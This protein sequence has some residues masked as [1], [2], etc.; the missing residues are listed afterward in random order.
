M[1]KTTT[2]LSPIVKQGQIALKDPKA[3]LATVVAAIVSV[4]PE[5]EGVVTTP[6]VPKPLV[7]DKET[8]EALGQIEAVFAAV[9]PD[10]A[11]VLTETEVAALFMEQTT[12]RTVTTLLVGRDEVIKEYVRNHLDRVAEAS[13]VANEHSSKDANGHYV[14]CSKGK[15]ERLP[16]SGTNKA[17][18]R[19]YRAGKPTV[20]GERLL[21]MYEAGDITREDYLAFT[22]EVRVFDE[23]KAYGAIVSKPE[24]LEILATLAVP[25]TEST[26]IFV[27][28]A[29]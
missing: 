23:D 13:G 5:V 17:W 1:T 18:S 12:L 25:A 19:E 20:N 2:D 8:K 14:V 6:E 15:P 11:R 24:R 26:S 22:R 29:K 3:T 7:L 21:E 27:R 16:I 10:T 28:A 9:Q 4:L